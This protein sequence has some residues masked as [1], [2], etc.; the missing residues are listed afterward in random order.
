MRI[1]VVRA[2]PGIGDLLCAV[3][4][5]RALRGAFPDDHVDLVAL[6]RTRALAE[7]FDRHFDRVVAFPGWPGLPEEPVDVERRDALL[8]AADYD[9]AFQLHGSGPESTAFTEALGARRT[10]APSPWREDRSEVLWPLDVLAQAGV[11]PDGTELELPF[12][13]DAAP[14]VPERYVVIHPGSTLPDR[15]WPAEAFAAAADALAACGGRHGR[16]RA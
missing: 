5:L 9:L 7:R 6:A 3:P 14:P 10:F 4:A 16:C 1:A 12:D 13:P 11:A 2:L 15:R 8:A